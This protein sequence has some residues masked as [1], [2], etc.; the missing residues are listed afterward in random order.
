MI[1]SSALVTPRQCVT[2]TALPSPAVKSLCPVSVF[3]VFFFY[4]LRDIFQ[5]IF[6]VNTWSG[7]A[8]QNVRCLHFMGEWV[9]VLPTY[10]YT[11]SLGSGAGTE[12]AQGPG[13][14]AM[15]LIRLANTL[16]L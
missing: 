6:A 3:A 12:A 2:V 4:L 8:P 1:H 13:I 7:P 16:C 11:A 5:S 9:I 10:V 14:I 15:Y